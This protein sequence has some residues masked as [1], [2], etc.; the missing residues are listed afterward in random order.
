MLVILMTF[1]KLWFLAAEDDDDEFFED[2]EIVSELEA[3]QL[4]EARANLEKELGCELFKKVYTI[5]QV[6]NPSA[7]KA[8]VGYLLA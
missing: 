4:E 8:C 1:N 3:S 5:V 2:I 7:C 6:S